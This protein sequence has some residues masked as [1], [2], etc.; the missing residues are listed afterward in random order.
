MIIDRK[1][2]NC[3]STFKIQHTYIKKCC[4]RSCAYAYKK[5]QTY[6][7]YKKFCEECG[8]E[9]LPARPSEGGRFCG[10]T[11]SGLARRRERVD[12]NGYWYIKMPEHPNSSKQGYIAEHVLV[13]EE[14]IGRYLTKG[15]VVH[16][17]DC[18]K[19]HNEI[20]NLRLMTDSDHKSLHV[21][22]IDIRSRDE[23]GRFN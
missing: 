16:H 7:K 12:R 3:D 5:K 2:L 4:T 8:G 17:V 11:C 18:D 23:Y 15:E 14:S 10:S 13:I 22:F 6:K 21:A 9:F 1:C 19:R 20:Q